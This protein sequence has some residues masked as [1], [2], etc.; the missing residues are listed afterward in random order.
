[1]YNILSDLSRLDKS[2]SISTV[3]SYNTKM[4]TDYFTILEKN[5]Q[6]SGK[7]Q[8]YQNFRKGH[9]AENYLEMILSFDQR[10]QLTKFRLSSHKLVIETGRYSKPKTPVQQK[11]CVLCNRNEIE[12]EKHLFLKCSLY[13]K[14]RTDFFHIVDSQIHFVN[15]NSSE[16]IY[17]LLSIQ[18]TSSSIY[19]TSKFIHMCFQLRESTI[20]EM[21]QQVL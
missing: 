8:F 7:L 20:Q 19:S 13:S 6:N 17:A 1:M 9:D 11:L 21:A 2:F 12:T 18:T 4:K 10:R 15:P 3:E 5:L 14:L 16:Y